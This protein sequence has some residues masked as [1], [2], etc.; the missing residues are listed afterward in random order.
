MA[1]PVPL[2]VHVYR[3]PGS[4]SVARKQ[5]TT[6]DIGLYYTLTL[7]VAYAEVDTVGTGHDEVV[8]M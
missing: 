2:V 5:W 8:K 6:W 1:N 7:G 3:G 4:Q